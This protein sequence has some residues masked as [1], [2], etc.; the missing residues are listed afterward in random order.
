MHALVFLIVDLVLTSR[1]TNK[2]Y[3]RLSAMSFSEQVLEKYFSSEFVAF[4]K[5]AL[6][7]A[8]VVVSCVPQLWQ[9]NT[10]WRVEIYYT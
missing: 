3:L 6:C 9:G 8:G 1:M 5:L 4:K 7:W 2:L 10:L